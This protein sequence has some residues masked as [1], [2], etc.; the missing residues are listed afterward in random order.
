MTDEQWRIV[1]TI[2][3][4][5]LRRRILKRGNAQELYEAWDALDELYSENKEELSMK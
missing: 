4:E 2:L 1:C 3:S 5:E